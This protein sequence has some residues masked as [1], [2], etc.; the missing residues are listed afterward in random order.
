M[1]E[2]LT[3]KRNFCR[4]GVALQRHTERHR[5]RRR[6][7]RMS[8]AAAL[9]AHT[10]HRHDDRSAHVADLAQVID[11][12]AI[13]NAKLRLGVDPLG[14]AGVHYWGAIAEQHGIELDVI[15]EVLD[16]SFAF[17][18]LD[19]D[20]QVCMDP[21]SGPAMARLVALND[22]YDVAFACEP[23]TNATASSHPAFGSLRGPRARKLF[24]RSTL[25][26]LE[27]RRIC[28]RW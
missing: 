2:G 19:W 15:S 12:N 16:P 4:P 9:R 7:L 14:G 5:S 18:T 28:K 22:Q 3:V 13:R 26:A 20:G 24:T 23:S 21:S 8:H 6:S 1:N 17:M 27:V 11:M 10:T 25:R